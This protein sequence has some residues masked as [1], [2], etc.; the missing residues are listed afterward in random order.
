MG[1]RKRFNLRLEM[2]PRG[3]KLGCGQ[4]MKTRGEDL[5]GKNPEAPAMHFFGV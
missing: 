3:K 4:W 2:E 5:V 1:I